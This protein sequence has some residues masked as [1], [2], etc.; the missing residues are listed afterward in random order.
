MLGMLSNIQFYL[1]DVTGKSFEVS[2]VETC[3][4]VDD[5]YIMINT[6]DTLYTLQFIKELNRDI[7]FDNIIN[8]IKNDLTNC[9]VFCQNIETKPRPLDEGFVWK[10]F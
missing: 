7:Y 3:A 9:N 8:C 1:Q 5:V 4:R 10:N 2:D 6:I